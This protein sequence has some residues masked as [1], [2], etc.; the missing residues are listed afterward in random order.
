MRE[1]APRSFPLRGGNSAF[2]VEVV[3]NG[4][5]GKN[6]SEAAEPGD[7]SDD[8]VFDQGLFPE[9]FPAGG[10]A[11]VNFHGGNARI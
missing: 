11:Q 6:I 10:V 2:S 9:R 3:E 1:S 5:Q 7:P 8:H 4:V